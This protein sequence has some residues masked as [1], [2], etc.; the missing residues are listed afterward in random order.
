MGLR[1]ARGIDRSRRGLRPSQRESGGQYL[2][3]IRQPYR[4][5]IH[6]T[7][8]NTGDTPNEYRPHRV[9]DTP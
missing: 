7:R 2:A 8:G 1:P 9:R 6:L 5:F 4:R 3:A